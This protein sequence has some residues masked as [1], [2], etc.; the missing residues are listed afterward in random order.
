MT[1]TAPTIC[2]GIYSRQ[3]AGKEGD[4]VSKVLVQS[5]YTP[6][7]KE[8]TPRE[9]RQHK[10]PPGISSTLNHCITNTAFSTTPYNYKLR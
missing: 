6:T 5:T 10:Y 1:G 4:F 3:N 7:L 8:N 9:R 2:Y